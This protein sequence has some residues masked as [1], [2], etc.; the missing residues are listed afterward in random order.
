MLKLLLNEL[1]QIA[2]MRSIKGYKIMSEER[3]ISSIN[4]AEPVEESE[5][6]F[7]DARIENIKKD[8]KNL[9]DRLSKPK[10][11]RLEKI[12]IENKIKKRD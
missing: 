11:E 9:K 10:K 5:K 7:D 4:E 6:N 2:K 12:F 1:K 8:F 3:L